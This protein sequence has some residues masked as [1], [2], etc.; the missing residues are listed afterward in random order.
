MTLVVPWGEVGSV[1]LTA[2]VMILFAKAH[3]RQVR[4]Q[5]ELRGYASVDF[6]SDANP[7]WVE[8]LWKRD[9]QRFW[10]V[11]AFVAALGLAG[12][13]LLFPGSLPLPFET[14]AQGPRAPWWDALV[15]LGWALI[16]AFATAGIAG[17]A[18]F[19]R[20]AQGVEAKQSKEWITDA[21][22]G[23]VAWWGLAFAAAAAWWLVA[24]A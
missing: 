19:T 14:D 7:A 8:E 15:V 24:L 3:G 10:P 20:D 21:R 22:R 4:L 13:L 2:G 23:S 11:L 16:A 9:R 18:E 6:T 5:R 12:A 17:W 1:A